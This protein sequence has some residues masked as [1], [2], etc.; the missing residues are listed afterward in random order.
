MSASDISARNLKARTAAAIDE[1]QGDLIDLSHRIHAHPETAFKE[2]QA[3]VWL[4]DMLRRHGLS[5]E[6]GI[7]GLPTAFRATTRGTADGPVV[8]ILG[9]YDA[10]PEIGHGCGHNI[11]GTAAVGAG[12]TLRRVMDSLD[13]T[14]QIIGTPAEEGGGGKVILL[15]AG[16]FSGIDAA[17]I[18]HPASR[19]MVTRPSLASNRLVLEFFGKA[20]HAAS[21]PFEGIN[22]L[23]AC[24]LT[25]VNVNALR[26]HVTSDVRI[27][28][29][30]TNGGAA[31]NI[32][33]EY[34]S[35]SF[36][37][38]A[39]E[40]DAARKVMERVVACA[41]AGAAAAGAR[42][43]ATVTPGYDNIR[44]NRALAA[45][46]KAN[47]EALGEPVEEPR[48]D[49]KMGSTDMGNVSWAVPAIHPY[50]AIV[51][52]TVAGHSREFCQ[53]AASPAGDRGLILA[54]KAM[55]ATAVDLF[56]DPSLLARA[57]A[58]FAAV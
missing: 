34:A 27:H 25:F 23:D 38:R 14:V 45:A 8:A 11:M 5:V 35:A 32:V 49:E 33:P 36:S 56:T 52:E 10:L 57:K 53:A 4:S 20:A 16:V 48:P 17:M 47:M 7:G 46:F 28:G 39:A 9:E 26:Q 19:T 55:A 29:I 22:A 21:T 44:P 3:S 37:V 1:L 12:I 18:V 54:A 31:V 6:T 30:I 50:I 2:E 42:V 40:R 15:N 51:P 41:E 43:K 58:E 13:G 24:I